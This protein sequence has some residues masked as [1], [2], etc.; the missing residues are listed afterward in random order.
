MLSPDHLALPCQLLV[1]CKTYEICRAGLMMSVIRDR[2]EV[3]F[4]G[5]EDRF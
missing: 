1:L 5:G 4:R 2:P 3:A